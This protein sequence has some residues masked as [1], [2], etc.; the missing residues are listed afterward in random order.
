MKAVYAADDPSRSGLGDSALDA[1]WRTFLAGVARETPDSLAAAALFPG[2]VDIPE[3]RARVITERNREA[4]SAYAEGKY[5]DALERYRASDALSPNAVAVYGAAYSLL[6][7]G[8]WRDVRALAGR[9]L[10][11]S[12]R[13]HTVLPLRLFRGDAA[14]MMED[15]GA[16]VDDYSFL[17]R[18]RP[19]G[20]PTGAASKRLH[21][22]RFLRS[23]DLVM[24]VFLRAVVGARNTD[25]LRAASVADL[26]SALASEPRSGLIVLELASR[27]ALDSTGREEARRLLAGGTDG[28]FLR[29]C[30]LLAGR[31]AEEAGDFTA[32]AEYYRGA[33]SVSVTETERLEAQD[34]IA[35]CV[36]LE[37]AGRSI[38]IAGPSPVR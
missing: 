23:R 25:S 11:D 19:A 6:R 36:W 32:A 27:L 22:I 35:R 7:L 26:R 3:G 20:W 28:G 14:W 16:A 37:S 31:L 17:V 38:Q 21:A 4:A 10:A 2:T 1:E 34:R 30:R 8:R 13:S 29:E 24:R 12:A 33:L 9:V 18:E 5:G 15:T